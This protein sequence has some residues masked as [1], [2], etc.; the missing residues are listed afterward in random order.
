M[1]HFYEL[2]ERNID[3]KHEYNRLEK[4]VILESHWNGPYSEISIEMWISKNFRRWSGRGNYTSFAELRTHLGFSYELI[5]E[6]IFSNRIIDMNSFFLYC[7]MLLNL[8]EELADYVEKSLIEPIQDVRN[9]IMYVIEISGFEVKTIRSSYCIVL[10]NAVAVQAIE[11]CPSLADEIIEYNHYYLKGNVERKKEIL[12]KI[13][14]AIEP[15]K[16]RLNSINKRNVT[17]FFYLVNNMNLRHNNCVPGDKNYY[18]KFANLSIQQQEEWYDEIY[19]QGLTL[20]V[21]LGQNERNNKISEF[22]A[23]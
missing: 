2:L 21:L 12:L 1:L 20:F 7:E 5:G 23:E 6:T 16:D 4:M 10:K 13:A 11:Q 22:K 18:P 17:D 15:L 8:F 9:T 19:A 14:D 3:F